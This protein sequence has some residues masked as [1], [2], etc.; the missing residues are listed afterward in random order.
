MLKSIHM[1]IVVHF[2]PSLH[3]L[4]SPRGKNNC[5]TYQLGYLTPWGKYKNMIIW[6]LR[7]HYSPLG[8]RV[9]VNQA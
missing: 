6:P 5:S 4:F 9:H 2:K 8:K 3:T 1:Q 7:V